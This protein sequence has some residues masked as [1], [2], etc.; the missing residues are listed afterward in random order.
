MLTVADLQ[1]MTRTDMRVEHHCVEGW[2]AIASWHGVR[3]RDRGLQMVTVPQ[4]IHDMNAG[5]TT[6]TG[7]IVTSTHTTQT[8][9]S[10]VNTTVD[11]DLPL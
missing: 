8:D 1:R 4:L 2:S 6:T 5:T 3:L 7:T 11:R 9:A 10:I